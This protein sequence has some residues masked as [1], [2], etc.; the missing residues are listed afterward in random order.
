MNIYPT[1]PVRETMERWFGLFLELSEMYHLQIETY[2][3]WRTCEI[4]VGHDDTELEIDKE[5]GYVMEFDLDRTYQES[6]AFG[7]RVD[8]ESATKRAKEVAE[9]LYGDHLKEM[10]SD[11]TA[12]LR[13]Y[14][15]KKQWE[16][17]Y[18][19]FFHGIPLS[20]V[21]LRIALDEFGNLVGIDY[22]GFHDFDRKNKPTK[23]Q[24][25]TKDEAKQAYLALFQNNM[26]LIYDEQ[27]EGQLKYIPDGV[28]LDYAVIHAETG[29]PAKTVIG[30]R[31]LVEKHSEVI[32]V[33]PR[34]ES[35]FFTDIQ[36]IELWLKEHF[37]IDVTHSEIKRATVVTPNEGGLTYYPRSGSFKFVDAASDPAWPPTIHYYWPL[38]EDEDAETIYDPD[39]VC[40]T[41]NQTINELLA[42]TVN[43]KMEYETPRL[44]EY[45]ALQIAMR[46]L[47]KYM[48]R[49]IAELHYYELCY[50]RG[51]GNTY[52]FYER[53]QGIVLTNRVYN[54]KVNPW[55]GQVTGFYKH[56]VRKN[57]ELPDPISCVSAREAA[58]SFLGLFDAEL[59]YVQV[60]DRDTNRREKAP[61]PIPVYRLTYARAERYKYVDAITNQ[62]GR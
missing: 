38:P 62:P 2:D 29:Q 55:T 6:I 44:S 34:G 11:H 37:Q 28:P 27:E 39:F 47:E 51:T 14:R 54:V 56:D 22:R 21:H 57:K 18:R 7:E 16:L 5:T 17:Y 31:R 9:K 25:I 40:V 26:M 19:Y 42:F 43:Q 50:L 49:G 24:I 3:K 30:G 8:A 20:G 35:I 15:G 4:K 61:V 1:E 46:F 48:E 45:D 23:P 10:V 13:E 36:E 53:R 59:E 60:E 58:E 41:L 52:Y 32:P 12:N 33:V